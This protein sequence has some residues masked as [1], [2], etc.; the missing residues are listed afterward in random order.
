MDE[1]DAVRADIGQNVLVVGN[2]GNKNFV[3]SLLP[4]LRAE[5]DYGLLIVGVLMTSLAQTR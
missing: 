3:S 4:R 5:K 2:S 1:R